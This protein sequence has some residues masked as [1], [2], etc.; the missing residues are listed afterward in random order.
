MT[1]KQPKTKIK[2]WVEWETVEDY[3]G[4]H[5]DPQSDGMAD[6]LGVFDTLDEVYQF[7]MSLPRRKGSYKMATRGMRR[8]RD[9]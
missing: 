4:P 9:G 5:E 1:K 6:C 3:G 7:M 2:V 8:R